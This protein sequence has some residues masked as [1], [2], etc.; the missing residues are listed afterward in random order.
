MFGRR[1]LFTAHLEQIHY[2]ALIRCGKEIARAAG[3]WMRVAP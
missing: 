1:L 3:P 2:L